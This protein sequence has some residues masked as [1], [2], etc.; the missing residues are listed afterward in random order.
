[1]RYTLTFLD[2]WHISSGMSGGAELDSSVVKDNEGF[3]YVPG[4]TIKGLLREMA[5]LL[6]EDFT[7]LNFGSASDNEGAAIFSN[8]TLE[9]STKKLITPSSQ[10]HLY[11]MISSTALDENGLAKDG[12]LRSI[13][14]V[15]PLSLNGT[16]ENCSDEKTMAKAMAMIKRMG[17]N[18]NRGLGRCRFTVEGATI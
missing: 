16:I 15:V 18:R 7:L 13:E 2:Y 8:V 10:A 11:Q 12:S 14:V 9:T 3:A 4:K 6:D 1:M 5:L 17:L